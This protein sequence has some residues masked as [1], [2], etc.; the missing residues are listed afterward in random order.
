MNKTI[1]LVPALLALGSWTVVVKAD[2][3]FGT[4]TNLGSTVNSSAT[5]AGP[6]ISAD[7]LS[8]FFISNRPGGCGNDDLYVSTRATTDDPWG[9]PI[10]LGSTVNRSGNDGYPSI[11][12]DG[13][14]LYFSSPRPGGLGNGDIWVT[15]R[16]TKDA[17]WGPPVHLRPPV[18]SAHIELSQSI[19]ADGLSLYFSSDRPGGS[20]ARDLW[21]TVRATTEDAW[22]TP[23]NLGSAVNASSYDDLPSISRDGLMLFFSSNRPGG[24]GSVD[25]WATTRVTTDDLWGKAVNLGPTVNGPSFDSA[26]SVSADGSTLLFMSDRP[27]GLGALDIW[28]ARI[29]P[30]VD[31]DGDG[32]VAIGDL[33]RLIEHWGLDDPASDIGPTPF[34]DGVVDVADLEVLMSYWEKEI[35]DPTLVAHWAF[36]EAD[37][38]VARNSAANSNSTIVGVPAWQ[39]AAG[40][41][42]G[43]LELTG[44][45]FI[46]GGF[47]LN[48]ADG[49][50]SVLAWVKGGQP[51][52]GIVTQQGGMDWLMVDPVDGTL[53]TELSHSLSSQTAI[54]DGDWH[55]IGVT[56]DGS[57]CLLYVDDV[58][59]AQ[60]AEDAVAGSAGGVVI[61][62]RKTMAPGTFFT[63]LIDDVRIYNRAVKP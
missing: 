61:G 53:A 47:V 28:Q 56:W 2:F 60:N 11:S 37:G 25:L 22:S 58:L 18:N 8:L 39:P 48:P 54:T 33:L 57:A 16:E 49:P 36:D 14:T 27:G 34:G 50:F 38:S 4:P 63:G 43:A 1:L 59:E 42:G 45:T 24:A 15:T 23:V 21:V 35:D 3:A 29:V 46:M 6:S 20:G 26:P 52:Q 7:G 51:G 40:K 17:P 19:S 62:C 41:V 44:M 30:I 13:L 5:D 9:A 32:T 31:F 10:N 12:A 55:R